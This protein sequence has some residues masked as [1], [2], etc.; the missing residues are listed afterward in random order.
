MVTSCDVVFH[1]VSTQSVGSSVVYN[2]P[3]SSRGA[4]VT[5]RQLRARAVNASAIEEAVF[6]HLQA[7]R[8]LGETRTNSARI[9]AALGI[10]KNSVERAILSLRERGVKVIDD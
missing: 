4:V 7:I 10:K 1:P 2:A 5:R 8:S 3:V 6:A 9:A